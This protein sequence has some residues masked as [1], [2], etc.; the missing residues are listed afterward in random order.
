MNPRYS[1]P[2][3]Y[4]VKF[5]SKDLSS[6]V[7]AMLEDNWEQGTTRDYNAHCVKRQRLPPNGG[8]YLVH[9]KGVLRKLYKLLLRAII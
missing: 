2:L 6:R 7:L 9:M 1:L 5:I 3:T 8:V 4:I